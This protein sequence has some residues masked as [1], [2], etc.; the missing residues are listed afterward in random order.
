MSASD[1]GIGVAV[2]ARKLGISAALAAQP[3]AL[4][5]AE[6]MLLVDDH[7]AEVAE[8]RRRPR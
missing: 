3:L 8:R 6:A 7:Q 4:R 1:R 5:H 2:M